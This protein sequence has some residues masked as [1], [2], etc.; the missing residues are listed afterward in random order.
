MTRNSEN[1]QDAITEPTNVNDPADSQQ[2]F[3]AIISRE[4]STMFQDGLFECVSAH[5]L[6]LQKKGYDPKRILMI[7]EYLDG[8]P[9][10]DG[11]KRFDQMMGLDVLLTERDLF[12]LNLGYGLGR[13]LARALGSA[14]TFLGRKDLPGN[15][16][17]A[18]RKLHKKYLCSLEMLE[19]SYLRMRKL[20]WEEEDI[21]R[22]L[23]YAARTHK[24][25]LQK[26]ILD[27][28]YTPLSDRMSPSQLQGY[29]TDFMHDDRNKH[30][31][32]NH[33]IFNQNSA[34]IVTEE[35]T[36]NENTR[37]A[38]LDSSTD[39]GSHLRRGFASEESERSKFEE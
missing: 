16:H 21:A 23:R 28:Q 7:A 36:E 17:K 20:G 37:T 5:R 1:A 22:A 11:K 30:F 13:K 27:M 38:S 26:E 31:E 19:D 34:I 29:L 6:Q 4:E 10:A 25:K 3:S 18:V 9:F 39:S 12:H 35:N 8:Y 24:A 2:K 14:R 33:E 15:F 32:K